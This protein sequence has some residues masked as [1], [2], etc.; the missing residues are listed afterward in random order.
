MATLDVP[1]HLQRGRHRSDDDWLASALA[2]LGLLAETFERPDLSTT[3][4]LDVGCG[5]KLTK[6]ILEQGVPIGR[7][8][9]VDTADDIIEFLA[10][11]VD[12][13]RFSFHHLDAHNDLYNPHGRPLASYDRLPIGDDAFDIIS[14]FSVFTHL[15]PHD[16]RAMLEV[17][18]P[19]VAPDG[20]LLFSLFVDQG[21]PPEHREAF[22]REL[23]RRRDAGD[24]AVLKALE[25]RAAAE[26]AGEPLIAD[27]VDAVPD[28]PLLEAV[29][30]ERYARELIEGSGWEA[31]ELH[32]PRRPFI[33]HYFVCR[34]V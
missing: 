15:A 31:V 33:Q 8:V 10:A 19:H 16:Y 32:A 11:N 23:H 34:P 7:Y 20:G 6:V 28:R 1:K 9:G 5:T 25:A 13:P 26:A 21:V 18:R 22:E 12:D 3:T 27:F 14:L 24:P 30:S 29:Y 17:L 4:L 2:L